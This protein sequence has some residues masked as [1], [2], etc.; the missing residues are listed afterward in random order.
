[1]RA[2]DSAANQGQQYEA[3]NMLLLLLL[4]NCTAGCTAQ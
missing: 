1:V 2:G 4:L 3:L